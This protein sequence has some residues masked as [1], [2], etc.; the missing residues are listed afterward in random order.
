MVGTVL[1][2]L[3]VSGLAL[4]TLATFLLAGSPLL[5]QRADRATISGV[6]SD[7]QGAPVPGA[8]VTIKNEATAVETV[9]V[10]NDAGA[11]SS[12]LLVLG[13]YTV[14]VD[15][16]GFKKSV[17]SGILLSGGDQIRRDIAMQVGA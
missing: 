14:S 4:C 12:P 10:T 5:A 3:R 7:A 6:V 17:T 15:L 11:Y 16:A 2:S 13:R 8:T 1:G 9:L